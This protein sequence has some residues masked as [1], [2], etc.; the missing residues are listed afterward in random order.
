M[1]NSTTL[2][3]SASAIQVTL[4]MKSHKLDK[5]IPDGFVSEIYKAFK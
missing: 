1:I 4:K 3:S 5:E 2:K